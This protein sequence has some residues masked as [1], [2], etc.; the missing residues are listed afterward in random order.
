MLDLSS[1]SY[2]FFFTNPAD[3]FK[4]KYLFFLIFRC[5]VICKLLFLYF[6]FQFKLALKFK[7]IIIVHLL[8]FFVIFDSSKILINYSNYS[9]YSK[10]SNYFK[11]ENYLGSIKLILNSKHRKIRF[12]AYYFDRHHFIKFVIVFVEIEIEIGIGIVVVIIKW[13]FIIFERLFLN[14]IILFALYLLLLFL[15]GNS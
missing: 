2:V 3:L 1:S 4:E 7:Y 5:K 14:L 6:W 10:Y 11:I 15:K 9:K 8:W 12:D 13:N